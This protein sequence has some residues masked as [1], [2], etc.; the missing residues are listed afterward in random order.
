MPQHEFERFLALLSKLLK[1]SS[2]E[3]A[4]IADE[5]CDHL[6]ERYSEL[7]ASGIAP[8]EA[9]K[10]ALSEFDDASG[11]A[12]RLT[13]I[14]QH[15]K[16][17]R[18]MTATLGTTAAAIALIATTAFWPD[19]PRQPGGTGVA[20]AADGGAAT[21]TTPVAATVEAPT[22]LS[23]GEFLPE[24]L[25]KPL[26]ED[27]EAGTLAEFVKTIQDVTGYSVL[28][29]RNEL[30]ECGVDEN[31]KLTA[32]VKGAPAYLAMDRAFED[33]NGTQLGW[34]IENDVL[35]IATAGKLESSETSWSTM[36]FDISGLLKRGYSAYELVQVIEDTT[37]GPWEMTSGEGGTMLAYE[38]VL[39]ARNHQQALFEV[40]ALLQA[41]ESDHPEVVVAEPALNGPLADLLGTPVSLDVKDAPLTDVLALLEQQ[42]GAPIDIDEEIDPKTR[43]TTSTSKIPLHVMI[44]QLDE[45]LK[46][47]IS[48]GRLKITSVD[49][50][51]EEM[52]LAVFDV[53]DIITDN[54]TS[55][56]HRLILNTTVGPWEDMAGEGGVLCEL[57][58]GRLVAR[59]SR[60]AVAGAR[61]LI[62]VHRTLIARSQPQP[63][64][65]PNGV[66]IRYYRLP[67]KTADDLVTTIPR[68]VAPQTWTIV[69]NM[70]GGVGLI[71]KVYVGVDSG[72][73]MGG[74]GGGGGGFFQMGGMG[75]VGVSEGG[76][77]GGMGGMGGGSFGT[78]TPFTV[79][80]IQQT[81]AVHREISKFINELLHGDAMRRSG[82]PHPNDGISWPSKLEAIPQA[83]GG[84][85]DH[86]PASRPATGE[87]RPSTG[88]NG[89][90]SSRVKSTR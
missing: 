33:V 2:K 31:A 34:S 48:N 23:I 80:V 47:V 46:L 79:L 40:Q 10:K 11:L 78:T 35:T 36:S 59:G 39:T 75:G 15:R 30:L 51:D 9:V 56:L 16:R 67:E 1:L 68:F 8:D 55:A 70:N 64:L 26:P 19:Q 90:S 25:N 69:G 66:E 89:E 18:I 74:M 6:E 37:S 45:R 13:S 83:P 50:F 61:Q 28:L 44:D 58:L 24:G 29:D 27:Q 86:A 32:N 71:Q 41:L 85:H 5:I 22:Y 14:V 17:R 60:Q 88:A 76:T 4:A 53:R 65:D 63:P 12:S 77:G 20:H 49:D 72:F 87:L 84:G 82:T 3:T 43:I 73:G 62:A 21:T 81:R 54:D 42:I 57:A 52:S 7:V 38:N